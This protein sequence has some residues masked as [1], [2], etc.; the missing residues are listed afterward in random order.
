MV[1]ADVYLH[2]PDG[3]A[4]TRFTRTF[5]ERRLGRVATTRNWRTVLALAELAGVSAPDGSGR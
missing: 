2:T 3:F 1:G 5:L 4:T